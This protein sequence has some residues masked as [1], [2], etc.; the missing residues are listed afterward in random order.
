VE[1]SAGRIGELEPRARPF[2]V[3]LLMPG[4]LL[5]MD[6]ETAARV[7]SRL[8]R[9][10]RRLVLYAYGDVLTRHGGLRRLALAAGFDLLGEL[11][12]GPGA[13]AS[14]AVAT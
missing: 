12:E 10:A 4:R 9:L 14:E 5:E 7:R 6:C 11:S 13:Q 2:D 1:I 3:A 8:P